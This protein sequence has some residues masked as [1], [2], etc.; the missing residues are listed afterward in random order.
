MM[1]IAAAMLFAAVMLK[2]DDRPIAYEQLPLAAREFVAKYFPAEKVL[3][4]TEDRDIIGKSYEVAFAS[5]A[6]A[7]FASDGRWKEV[8]CRAV[9]VPDGIVPVQIVTKV[10]ELYPDATINY[11]DR[12][13]NE[14]EVKLSNRLELTFN[15]RYQLIEI[16]D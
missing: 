10:K 6:K 14:Y 16:D 7:E 15:N 8:D 9:P 4:V 13:P 3:Y 11:I 1:I 2:A 5:S 12:S